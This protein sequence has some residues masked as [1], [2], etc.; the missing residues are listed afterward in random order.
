M[1]TPANN[2]D[3]ILLSDLYNVGESKM[4]GYLPLRTITNYYGQDLGQVQK[5][6]SQKHAAGLRV[7]LLDESECF[8]ASGALYVAQIDKLQE[9]LSAP[10]Q[11]RILDAA[12]WPSDAT[13]FVTRVANEDAPYETELYHLIAMTFNSPLLNHEQRSHAYPEKTQSLGPENDLKFNSDKIA[14]N[15]HIA[16]VKNAHASRRHTS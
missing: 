7:F 6:L 15:R 4:L 13:L 14:K 11:Q 8:I 12:S 5:K 16:S 9:F 1:T 3:E 2:N 10:E